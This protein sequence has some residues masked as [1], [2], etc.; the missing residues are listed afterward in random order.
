MTLIASPSFGNNG[1]STPTIGL[2]QAQLLDAAAD[3]ALTR[4]CPPETGPG[5]PCAENAEQIGDPPG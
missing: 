1:T 3:P 2:T 5:G 4:R